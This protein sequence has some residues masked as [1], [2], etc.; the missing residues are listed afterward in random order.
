MIYNLSVFSIFLSYLADP[1]HLIAKRHVSKSILRGKKNT[2][3]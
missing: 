3:P 2:V 1:A